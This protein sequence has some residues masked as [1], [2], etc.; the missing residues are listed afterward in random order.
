[1]VAWLSLMGGGAGLVR[2][3]ARHQKEIPQLEDLA[4]GVEDVGLPFPAPP[5]PE[6]A[7][8]CTV[9]IHQGDGE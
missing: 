4:G 9:Q 2:G 3:E 1:M 5:A 7:G 8:A 6:I